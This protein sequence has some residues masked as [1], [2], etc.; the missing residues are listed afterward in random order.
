MGPNVVPFSPVH[1]RLPEADGYII[2]GGYPELFVTELEANDRMREAI[3]EMSRN[4]TPVYAECGGLMY[5]TDRMV[6]KEGWQG[7]ED[8]NFPAM[9]GVFPGRDPDAGPPGRQLCGGDQ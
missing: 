5:L 1:D 6:L 9:C 3:R 2:G 7:Q 4:G 8:E